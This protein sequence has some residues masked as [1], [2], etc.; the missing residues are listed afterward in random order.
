MGAEN[1]SYRAC[2]SAAS[3]KFQLSQQGPTCLSSREPT[4]TA[5]SGKT[6]SVDFGI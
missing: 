3:K 1:K 4:V 6:K 5:T 2:W